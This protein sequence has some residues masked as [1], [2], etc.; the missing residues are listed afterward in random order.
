MYFDN[1]KQF[2]KA[3]WVATLPKAT[4]P[5]AGEDPDYTKDDERL[6]QQLKAKRESYKEKKLYQEFGHDINA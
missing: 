4:P 3:A 1:S 5:K 6:F 2:D